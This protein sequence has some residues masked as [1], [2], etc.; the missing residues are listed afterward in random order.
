MYTDQLHHVD[1][2]HYVDGQLL[3]A[4]QERVPLSPRPFADVA[5]SLDVPESLVLDRLGR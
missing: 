5:R 3:A 2:L 1:Q 4:V